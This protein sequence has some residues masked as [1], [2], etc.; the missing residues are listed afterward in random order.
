MR[1]LC[2]KAVLLGSYP[3]LLLAALW[4]HPLLFAAVAVISYLAEHAAARVARP[5]VDLLSRVHL[6]VTVRF[7]IR[8]M[9]ALLLVAKTT[10]PASPWFTALAVGLFA[11]HGV[12]AVQTGLAIRLRQTV[13]TMPVTTRHL[14][15]TALNLPKTPPEFLTNYRGVRFL[16]LDALPV[17]GAALGGPAAAAGA[18]LGLLLGCAGVLV[19]IPYV[20]R[21]APL[22]DAA[23]ILA[24]VDKQVRDYHPEVILYFSGANEAAYQARMWLATLE[25]IDRRAIVVLRERGLADRL[26]PTTL[27]VVCIPSSADLMGFHA[28]ASARVCLYVANVGKNI[29]MLRIPGMRSVFIGHGDSDKEASFNPFSRVYDEVWVAGPAGRDR[30][31]RARVGVRDESVHE[32]GRPQ[33][34]GISAEGPGLP[35]RTVLYAPTWEGW[36]DDLHHTSLTTMGPRIVRA[37]LDHEPK[38]RVIYKPHPLTGHRDRAAARAHAEIVA[39]LD[40]AE[41]ARS[42]ARHPSGGATR[43]PVKHLVVTKPDLYACFNQADMMITDISS[44]VADFLASGK[45]YAVTNVSGMADKAFHERYPTTGAG[46]LLGQDLAALAGFV[47]G[48]DALACARRKLR[49]YLLGPDEP[50]ALTRFN[51]AVE[52][53]FWDS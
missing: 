3:V 1:R 25:R 21:A 9:A 5:F 17:L 42:K 19:L 52:R 33:L 12:R 16:Y 43:A 41:L 46:V 6:G 47:D 2:V 49:A 45:P 22:S 14:D 30:Y 4:P 40:A 32:V 8:E 26:G 18:G 15:V 37:L 50:D 11:M 38:L 23:R 48:E 13:A 10:G 51:A 36:T 29:H 31:R 20:R 34:E 24:V 28:L 35:Y 7:V 27:P 53:A 44:V 39:M